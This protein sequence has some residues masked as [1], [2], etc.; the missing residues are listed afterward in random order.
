MH[1]KLLPLS[2][3]DDVGIGKD[4]VVII[5]LNNGILFTVQALVSVQSDKHDHVYSAPAP[6]DRACLT[7]LI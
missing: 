2:G 1:L 4:V 7:G 5:G 3:D 6:D